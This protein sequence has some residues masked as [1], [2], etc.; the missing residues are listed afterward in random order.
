MDCFETCLQTLETHLGESHPLQATLYCILA[1]YNSEIGN[2]E[3]A[4]Y[5]YKSSLACCLRLLGQSHV[6]TAEVYIDLG[7]ILSKMGQKQ[8]ALQH[9]EKAKSTLEAAGMC[10]TK[11]YARSLLSLA[12]LKHQLG[13]AKEAQLLST[14]GVKILE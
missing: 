9:F 6:Q 11:N 4:L 7:T 1:Y 10:K 8:E 14:T 3:D 2:L 5:L 13:G 12:A